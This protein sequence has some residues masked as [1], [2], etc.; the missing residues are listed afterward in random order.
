MMLQARRQPSSYSVL[1]EPQ[2]L[3]ST[4]SH[5][6][7]IMHAC[8]RMA[9]CHILVTLSVSL[10]INISKQMDWMRQ[11]PSMALPPGS[12]DQIPRTFSCRGTK[13]TVYQETIPDLKTLQNHI[14]KSTVT[15]TPATL[16][17]VAEDQVSP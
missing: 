7:L 5:N 6:C 15:M 11:W 13:N 10:Q 12:L 3:P 17:N 9:H 1:S 2:I 14:T 4:L 16:Q 8:S